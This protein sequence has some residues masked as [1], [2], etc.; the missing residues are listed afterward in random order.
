MIQNKKNAY[1]Y[2][3]FHIKSYNFNLLFKLFKFMKLFQFEVVVYLCYSFSLFSA[4]TIR[5]QQEV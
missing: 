2:T 1:D 4:V 5:E 3:I